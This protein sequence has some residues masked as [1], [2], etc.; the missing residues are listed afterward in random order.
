MENRI[1]TERV[2]FNEQGRDYNTFIRKFPKN[3][4]AGMF[5]FQKKAYFQSAEGSE[6]AP[7]IE[8]MK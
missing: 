2:R 6:N 4:W 7:D 1:A 8:V 5:G 3:L